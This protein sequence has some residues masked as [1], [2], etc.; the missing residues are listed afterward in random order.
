MSIWDKTCYSFK[1]VRDMIK[2]DI[3]TQIHCVMIMFAM[4]KCCDELTP[5]DAKD[6]TFYDNF[7]ELKAEIC[8][9]VEYMEDYNYEECEKIVNMW[10]EELYNLCDYARVWLS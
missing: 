6:W 7:I 2:Q 8:D 4:V 9:E 3:K 5:N 10:L 1:D